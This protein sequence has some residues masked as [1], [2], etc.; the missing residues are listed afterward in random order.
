VPFYYLPQLHTVLQRSVYP[1]EHGY[2]EGFA[3]SL[4]KVVN[5]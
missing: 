5:G 3:E 2:C 1:H 4:R